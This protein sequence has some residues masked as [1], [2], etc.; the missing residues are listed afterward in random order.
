MSKRPPASGI[1]KKIILRNEYQYYGMDMTVHEELKNLE[2][3]QARLVRLCNYI[4]NHH[5]GRYDDLYVK[6]SQV[7]GTIEE[8]LNFDV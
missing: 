7:I 8:A 3:V 6:L 4:E 1:G 5:S 2:K